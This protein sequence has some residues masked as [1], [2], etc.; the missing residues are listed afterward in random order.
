MRRELGLADNDLVVLFVGNAKPQKNLVG[1][2]RAVHRLRKVFPQVKL[3]A[4]TELKHSS[5]NTEMARVSAEISRL[6]L[7]SCIIQKGIVKNMP[8]LMRACDVLVAPFL[9]TF[10]PSDYF[11]AVLEAMA[12]GK[13]VVVA[14]VGGMSEVVSDEVGRL[15]NPRDDAFIAS[16][17]AGFLGDR[18]LREWAG[19]NARLLVEGDFQPARIVA[20]YRNI[21][22]RITS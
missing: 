9:D 22:Q 18:Q 14:D 21:Y 16:A 7:E 13:P 19:A 10:G 6:Q 17:L 15:V 11:M 12:C 5:S 3:V 8:A 1:A 4:T 2:L 20:A